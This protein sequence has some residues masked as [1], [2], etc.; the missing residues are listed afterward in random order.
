M[1][2]L[3]IAVLALGAASTQAAAASGHR[4][5]FTFTSTTTLQNRVL[6]QDGAAPVVA[7]FSTDSALV[8][9]ATGPAVANTGTCASWLFIRT[10]TSPYNGICVTTDTAGNT[11]S[12]VFVCRPVIA[13][14]PTFDCTGVLTG[15][16]GAYAGKSGAAYWSNTTTSTGSTSSGSGHIDD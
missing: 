8:T 4:A 5:T 6:G 16:A 10:R 3:I 11:V 13:P 9:Y 12:N 14:N 1:K 2:R 15:T 7:D